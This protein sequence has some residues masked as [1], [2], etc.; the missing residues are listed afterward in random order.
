MCRVSRQRLL[1]A[2]GI[3]TYYVG[4]W[5]EL[6]KAIQLCER[7]L[8]EGGQQLED[9]LILQHAGPAEIGKDGTDYSGTVADFRNLIEFIHS[10][11]SGENKS[12]ILLKLPIGDARKARL[13]S[14][15]DRLRAYRDFVNQETHAWPSNL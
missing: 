12:S 14:T 9:A 11:S 1:A 5:D 3:E 6:F 7:G 8:N 15:A 10:Y 2:P 13:E 4:D